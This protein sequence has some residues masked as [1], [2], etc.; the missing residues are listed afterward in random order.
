MAVVFFLLLLA[1]TW[2]LGALR[3]WPRG[4]VFWAG[5]AERAGR[6]GCGGRAEVQYRGSTGAH[7]HG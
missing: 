7:C 5:V 3:L 2:S 1:I 6:H 4:Y